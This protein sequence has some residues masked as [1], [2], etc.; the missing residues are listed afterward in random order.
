VKKEPKV[1]K[2]SEPV[3]VGGATIEEITIKPPKGKHIKKVDPNNLNM[4]TLLDIAGKCSGHAPSVFDEL[5]AGDCIAIC[6]VV[7]DF[8]G[9]GLETGAS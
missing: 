9:S 5:D 2:L 6:G 1:F 4:E 8:L 7:G 3:E